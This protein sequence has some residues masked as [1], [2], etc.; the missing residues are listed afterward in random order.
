MFFL[1]RQQT[2]LNPNST[3]IIGWFTG[4]FI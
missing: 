1:K 2:L 3:W 4:I